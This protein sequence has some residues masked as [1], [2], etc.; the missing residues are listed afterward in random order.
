MEN[1]TV[2]HVCNICGWV[3]DPGEGVSE[4]GIPPGISF[5]ELPDDFVC[6]ICGVGAEDFSPEE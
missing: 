3:Y 2:K 5:S 6:P 4:A 1:M